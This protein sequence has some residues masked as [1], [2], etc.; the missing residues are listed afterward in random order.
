MT[1]RNLDAFQDGV[2]DIL[3]HHLQVD[4]SRVI[5]LDKDTVPTGDFISVSDS[6]F[7]FRKEQE[8]GACWN[9]TIDLCGSG[10]IVC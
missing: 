1:R 10:I 5:A 6:P 8:I 3:S 2:N 9:S 4:A 7:D